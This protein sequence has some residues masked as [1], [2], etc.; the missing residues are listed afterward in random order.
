[1]I[2]RKC[3][4]AALFFSA[5]AL[6]V[7][8]RPLNPDGQRTIKVRIAVDEE[9]RRRTLRL[10]ETRKWVAA[11]SY[12]FEKNFGLALQIEDLR[13]W[14][15]DNSK[16]TLSGLVQNLYEE[17]E[18]GESD[19]VLGFT[20]QIRGESEVSGVASYRHG[21][22]LVKRMRQ[23]YLTRV[24][25][26]HELCHLFGAVDLEKERSIMNRNEP[27]LECDEF[28]RKIILLNKNRRFH[29]A[30][31]PLSP[32]E[33]SSAMALYLERKHLN[34]GEAGVPL[35]L[36][37]FYLE[38]KDYEKAVQECLEAE[39]LEPRDA[40]IQRLLELANSEDRRKEANEKLERKRNP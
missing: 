40:A 23:E 24:T 17:I 34:R 14:G 35:M 36:A 29:P 39:K 7:Y 1:M 27:R 15:S 11:A 12:F 38:L 31:F 10:H 25:V 37:I 16:R 2:S 30:V 33:M 3:V 28:T 32:E 18:K 21:Y 22:A 20:G 4:L 6:S 8:S 26:I 19:I 9:F 5:L 13:Y